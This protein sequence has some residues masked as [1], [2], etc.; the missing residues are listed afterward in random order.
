MNPETANRVYLTQSN[1]DYGKQPIVK[2]N[3]FKNLINMYHES[4]NQRINNASTMTNQ[5]E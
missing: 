1:A 3:R 4:A 2:M 5:K